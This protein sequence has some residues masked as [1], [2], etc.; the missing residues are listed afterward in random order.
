[1]EKEALDGGREDYCQKFFA[2]CLAR[3][4]ITSLSLGFPP[5]CSVWSSP[6]P[7]VGREAK[8]AFVVP[9]VRLWRQAES[10]KDS[11]PPLRIS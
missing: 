2:V 1:M 7:P 11:P 10:N 4:G 8:T 5:L 6:P 3:E 9:F